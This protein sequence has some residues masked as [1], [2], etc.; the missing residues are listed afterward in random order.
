MINCLIE[1]MK[2]LTVKPVNY[3]KVKELQ[4]GQDENPAVFQRRLV[5][6]F[7]QYGA[8]LVAQMVKNP[9]PMQEIRV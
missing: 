6:A 3:E 9:P 2:K 7:R 8:S 4:Q 1:S 5:E